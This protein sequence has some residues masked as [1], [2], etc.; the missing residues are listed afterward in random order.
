MLYKSLSFNEKIELLKKYINTEESEDIELSLNLFNLI[1]RGNSLDDSFFQHEKIIFADPIEFIDIKNALHEELTKFCKKLL[2]IYYSCIYTC[3]NFEIK[4]ENK[5]IPLIYKYF[6]LQADF[7]TMSQI[8]ID[9]G[10]TNIT[11]DYYED[12]FAIISNMSN[13]LNIFLTLTEKTM[14]DNTL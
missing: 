14:G 7:L 2:D 13:K 12:S 4:P 8:C 1:K 11:G 10:I 9:Y 6:L 5:K 3:N